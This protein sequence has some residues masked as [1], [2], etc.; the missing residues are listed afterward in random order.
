MTDIYIEISK[1]SDKFRTMCY[2]LTKDKVAINKL[3]KQIKYYDNRINKISDK[4][5]SMEDD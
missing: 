4:L 2:G 5:E 3:D 1:L